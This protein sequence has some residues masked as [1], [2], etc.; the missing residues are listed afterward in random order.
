MINKKGFTLI[1]LL[2]VVAIIG[3]LAAVGAAV[4]PGLLENTKVK[5]CM[6]N[7]DRISKFVSVSLLGCSG[8]GYVNLNLVNTDGKLDLVSCNNTNDTL[9]REFMGH[10]EGK[11]F[12]SPFQTNRAQVKSGDNPQTGFS[13][14][15]GMSPQT[16]SSTKTITVSSCCDNKFDEDDPKMANSCQKDGTLLMQTYDCDFCK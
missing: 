12:M 4:I 16:G 13:A 9:A 15:F 8:L 11:K 5:A 3:I 2:I 7:H 14:I 10:F 6:S 1:E